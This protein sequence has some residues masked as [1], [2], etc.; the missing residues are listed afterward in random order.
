MSTIGPVGAEKY[1]APCSMH[2]SLFLGKPFSPPDLVQRQ[3]IMSEISC[4]VKEIRQVKRGVLEGASSHE[5]RWRAKFLPFR[6]SSAA[7]W[8]RAPSVPSF[9][10]PSPIQPRTIGVREGD[11]LA[12]QSRGR[13]LCLPRAIRVSDYPVELS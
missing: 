12:P 2:P 4:L 1:G 10:H 7:Q 9:Y 6:I 3:V 5:A 13:P 11:V 8:S